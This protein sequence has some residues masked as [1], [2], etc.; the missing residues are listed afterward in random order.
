MQKLDAITRI[1]NNIEHYLDFKKKITFKQFFNYYKIS[2]SFD[3]LLKLL[4]I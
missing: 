1:I 3:S 4:F 2:T